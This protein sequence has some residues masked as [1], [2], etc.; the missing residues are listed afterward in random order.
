MDYNIF[1]NL[2]KMNKT[3]VYRVSKATGI[4]AA[5]Q[6]HGEGCHSHRDDGPGDPP[7]R[8]QGHGG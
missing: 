6:Q 1:E 3:T 8:G 2:L 5:T 4:A 7:H